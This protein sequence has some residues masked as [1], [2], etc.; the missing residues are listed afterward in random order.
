MCIFMSYHQKAIKKQI[1]WLNN[2]RQRREAMTT[3]HDRLTHRQWMWN[4]TMFALAQDFG[5][6]TRFFGHWIQNFHVVLHGI[7]PIWTRWSIMEE[8]PK[9]TTQNGYTTRSLTASI[10][11]SSWWHRTPWLLCNKCTAQKT[12]LVARYST[13]CGMVCTDLLTVLISQDSTSCYT[14]LRCNA[15]PLICQSVYQHH[16]SHAVGWIQVY[17]TRSLFPHWPEW[18]MLQK[19][20]VKSLANFILHN[21]IYRLGTLLKIVSNNGAPFVKALSYLSK[22]YHIKHIRISGYNSRANGLV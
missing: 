19:E 18:E 12:V 10:I 6:T 20:S 21:I 7:L 9:R 4:Y 5:T 2:I 16:A 3:S 1:Q 8:G 17:R 15:S 14:P 11:S 13:R 22:H